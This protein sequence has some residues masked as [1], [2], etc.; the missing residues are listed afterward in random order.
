[1]ST[2]RYNFTVYF[3]FAEE[4]DIGVARG[5]RDNTLTY[6]LRLFENKARFAC[7]A[8]SETR[9]ALMLKG[10]VNL[11][12][13]C[14][15]SFLAKMIGTGVF[16]PAYYGDVLNFCRL[17]L[18]DRDTVTIGSLPGQAK[19]KVFAA[20]PEGVKRFFLGALDTRDG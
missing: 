9:T 4:K 3:N 15:K 17:L 16:K 13:P 1:M 5:M 14:Q 12:S 6:L 19:S 20:D 8:R 11:N 7:I 2:K 18:I 10:Y